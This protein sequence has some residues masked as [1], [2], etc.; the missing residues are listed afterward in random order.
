MNPALVQQAEKYLK[1]ED[2]TLRD[3]IRRHGPCPLGRGRSDYFNTLAG[4]IVSQQLSTR[5][6]STIS[7]RVLLLTGSSMMRAEDITRLRQP[8]LRA[9]GLSNNKAQFLLDLAEEYRSGNL[10]FRSLAQKP[11]REVIERLVQL[12]GIGSWT[13]EMFLMFALRRPDIASPKDVGLKNAMM[14][15]YGLRKKPSEK[16]FLRIARRW[17]PYR[18]VACWYLWRTVDPAGI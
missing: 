8:Q 5:A 1:R 12:R 18:T 16:T 2:P 14:Q 15:M 7:N 6:A 11:D 9:A 10:N 13:A 3:V 4:S 17:A